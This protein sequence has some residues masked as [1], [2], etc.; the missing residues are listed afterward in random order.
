MKTQSMIKLLAITGLAV[1]LGAPLTWG[2]ESSRAELRGQLNSK[3]YK[4]L[5]EASQGGQM[6]VQLGELAKQNGGGQAVRDF[7]ERMVNDHKKANDELKQLAASKQ[8]TPETTITSKEDSRMNRLQKLSGVDFDKAYLSDMIKDHKKDL[9]EFEEAS[10]N[11]ADPEL[12]AFAEKTLPTIQQHL[13][14]AQDLY[15]QL[16]K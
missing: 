4:F 7:G 1:G 8:A 11:A 3:D 15:E 6:E 10:K 13:Q 5:S 12:R 16:K 2:A 14:T 9:K